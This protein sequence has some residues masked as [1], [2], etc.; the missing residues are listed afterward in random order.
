MAT[1]MAKSSDI[2]NGRYSNG[3]LSEIVGSRIGWWER[4][5]FVK[6]PLDVTLTINKQYA[7][8][9]DLLAYDMYG[10]ATLQWF[11]MQ[12]NNIIDV[13]EDFIEGTVITLPSRGRLFGELLSKA[14]ARSS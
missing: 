2:T 13:N 1:N 10:R 11:V 6:S 5:I 8:R 12:Y 3:G 7:R 14:A 4:T 9:P